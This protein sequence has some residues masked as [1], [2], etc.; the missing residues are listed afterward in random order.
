MKKINKNFHLNLKAHRYFSF[1][2]FKVLSREKQSPFRKIKV[3]FTLH[4]TNLLLYF[5]IIISI[6]EKHRVKFM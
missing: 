2:V 6:L 5:G 4:K 1:F 3:M